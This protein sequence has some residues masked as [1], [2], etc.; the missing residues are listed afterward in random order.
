[1]KKQ[2]PI[3]PHL[4][5]YK[6]QLTSVLSIMHRFTGVALSMGVIV[7]CWWLFSLSSG[8]AAYGHFISHA[9]TWYGKLFMVGWLF[10]FYYHLCNGL[11]HLYWDIGKGYGLKTL[12]KTGWLVVVVS[13]SL[14]IA[15][16]LRVS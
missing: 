9:K 3:S 14:T 7:L 8:G 13:I 1:M 12:Y 2:R 4:Q 5:V 10:S 16:T 11:R 6:P 15:T